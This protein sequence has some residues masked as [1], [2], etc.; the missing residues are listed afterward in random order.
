MGTLKVT[1]HI[2]NKN[3]K[4]YTISTADLLSVKPYTALYL[5]RYNVEESLNKIRSIVFASCFKSLGNFW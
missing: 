3:D 1:A 2:T 4:G 5:T